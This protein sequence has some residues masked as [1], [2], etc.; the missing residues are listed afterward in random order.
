MSDQ[1]GSDSYR[2]T[3]ET[4]VEP[5]PPQGA[6]PKR[7]FVAA[8][9]NRRT[10]T[11][12]GL[13]GVVLLIIVAVVALSGK[14]KPTAQLPLAPSAPSADTLVPQTRHYRHQINAYENTQYKQ[15]EQTGQSVF[16]L[17][18]YD[19][20]TGT[21]TQAAPTL[22]ATVVP[23]PKLDV[24][25]PTQHAATSAPASQG[26]EAST[27][28]TPAQA[29]QS[30]YQP[31]A[32]GQQ[33]N[34]YAQPLTALLG[35]EI[36]H[37]NGQE[38]KDLVTTV[39]SD[40]TSGEG[41]A[42]GVEAARKSSAQAAADA[43]AA[44]SKRA[45]DLVP[46][47]GTMLPAEIMNGLDSDTPGVVFADILSGPLAG[48][49]VMGA[50]SASDYG[51]TIQF[52]EMTVPVDGGVKTKTVPITAVAI[53]RT[54][55][56]IP[57]KINDHFLMNAAADFVAGAGTAISSVLPES[58]S[59]TATTGSGLAI[60]SLPS[61]STSQLL[62]TAGAAGL[63]SIG[64][65]YLQDFGNRSPTIT[66]AAGTPFT[67][68]F[69]GS[70]SKKSSGPPNLGTSGQPTV[71]EQIQQNNTLRSQFGQGQFPQLGGVGEFQSQMSQP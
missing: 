30:A 15:A 5:S 2:V 67:L 64:N 8:L 38:S 45:S 16:P 23:A 51:M 66:V 27:D 39:A 13:C 62:G 1:V 4:L 34:P 14:A 68:A 10:V 9:G 43:R 56:S 24:A 28:P 7:S 40:L 6:P 50:F 3:S 22:S 60:S 12:L 46:A 21:P 70:G 20:T 41:S 71:P 26:Q 19:P 29:T 58:G 18:D 44:A 11:W 31:E 63:S 49:R 59:T 65:Q 42:A 53:S 47:P 35:T 32:G 57:V 33:N 48:S 69:V 25:K 55:A 17:P 54:K 37:Q 61:F 36:P 52:T